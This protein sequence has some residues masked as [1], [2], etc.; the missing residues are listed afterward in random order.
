M[1]S[2]IV[3]NVEQV[4]RVGRE[5]ATRPM[6]HRDGWKR[7]NCSN[8]WPLVSRT[9]EKQR[10]ESRWKR[11]GRGEGM[12]SVP[13]DPGCFVS[14]PKMACESRT[15]TPD[16][17]RLHHHQPNLSQRGPRATFG[18]LHS[19]SDVKRSKVYPHMHSSPG[20]IFYNICRCPSSR[21]VFH[22]NSSRRISSP[23]LNCIPNSSAK[24]RYTLYAC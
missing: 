6:E 1:R 3:E 14:Q 5:R 19:P 2:E 18:M 22:P 4:R 21:Q 15:R 20:N 11:A 16:L 9:R 8:K 10:W 17:H 24:T 13:L 23:S 12:V 7:A